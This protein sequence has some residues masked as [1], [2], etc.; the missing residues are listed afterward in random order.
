MREDKGPRFEDHQHERLRHREKD[1]VP[2][3]GEEGRLHEQQ[4]ENIQDRVGH[5]PGRP[6]DERVGAHTVAD[7][8]VHS[9]VDEQIEHAEDKEHRQIDLREEYRDPDRPGEVHIVPS[10]K[11]LYA[12][13]DD[14][15]LKVAHDIQ[16]DRDLLIL[17]PRPH[18]PVQARGRDRKDQGAYEQVPRRDLPARDQFHHKETEKEHRQRLIYIGSLE[19][20]VFQ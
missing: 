13:E 15:E 3:A 2:L 20:V 11:R 8:P 9:Q 14:R 17:Y 5:D 18:I 1:R 19:Y 4:H 10:A 16:K 6:E 12:Q 7:L